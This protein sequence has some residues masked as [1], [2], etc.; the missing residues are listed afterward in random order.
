[1]YPNCRDVRI[2]G[3]DTTLKT[4]G[5]AVG[6]MSA[7]PTPPNPTYGGVKYWSNCSELPT[8]DRTYGET[9]QLLNITPEVNPIQPG[10]MVLPPYD[11]GQG[12]NPFRRGYYYGPCSPSPSSCDTVVYHERN[13]NVPDQSRFVEE[14]MQDDAHRPLPRSSSIYPFDSIFDRMPGADAESAWE[15]EMSK[16]SAALHRVSSRLSNDSYA[17]TSAYDP[18]IRLSTGPDALAEAAQESGKPAEKRDGAQ[19]TNFEAPPD[20]PAD[21]FDHRRDTQK[22]TSLLSDNILI[23]GMRTKNGKIVNIDK[24][25]RKLDLAELERLRR[26]NPAAVREASEFLANRSVEDVADVKTTARAKLR[27]IAAFKPEYSSESIFSNVKDIGRG[28]PSN[29]SVSERRLL[30]TPDSFIGQNNLEWSDSLC[31]FVTIRDGLS[32]GQWSPFTDNATAQA[33][34]VPSSPAGVAASAGGRHAVELGR[35]SEQASGKR[36]YC[37][38]MNGQT[39]LHELK[40]LP[41]KRYVPTRGQGLTDAELLRR[42]PAWTLE[43]QRFANKTIGTN[44]ASAQRSSQQPDIELPR[45]V[46]TTNYE[47]VAE[48]DVELRKKIDRISDT[49]SFTCGFFPF[50]PL[51]FYFGGF[52]GYMRDQ[53]RGRWPAMKRSDKR[54]SLFLYLPLGLIAWALV[55]T[56]IVIVTLRFRGH[57]DADNGQAAFS[58]GKPTGIQGGGPDYTAPG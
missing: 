49:V 51:V 7:F 42:E 54:K 8:S 26:S 50:L 12:T 53:T 28:T 18:E 41:S 39:R 58:N 6:L 13:S 33:L 19:R 35:H 52:D 32:H 23:E 10:E 21:H 20:A 47:Y 5:S 9:N 46:S 31:D 16:S 15:T 2:E 29:K 38:A 45:L 56:V 44:T 37:P 30:G 17:D 1:M 55:A 40:L 27:K 24:E 48:N 25:Q 22:A 43:P 11:G 57:V 3:H 34:A 14:G 36:Q 4:R